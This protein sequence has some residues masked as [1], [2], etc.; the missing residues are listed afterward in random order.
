MFETKGAALLPQSVEQDSYLLGLLNSSVVNSMQT[1]ISPTLDYHEGPLG[2]L[3]VLSNCCDKNRIEG[4]VEYNVDWARA[5][6]DSL[7]T[8]WDFKRCPLL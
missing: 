4:F 8:S 3:P 2:K 5:D 6:W 1:F 7:E